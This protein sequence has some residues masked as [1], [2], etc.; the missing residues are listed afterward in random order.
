MEVDP[1]M[2]AQLQDMVRPFTFNPDPNDWMFDPEIMG[3]TSPGMGDMVNS[4]M[5]GLGGG[6]SGMGPIGSAMGGMQGFDEWHSGMTPGMAGAG[7]H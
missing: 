2:F 7:G 6:M 3:L 4:G 5:G 1:N